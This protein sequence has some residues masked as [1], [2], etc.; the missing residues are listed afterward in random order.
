MLSDFYKYLIEKNIISKKKL[1]EAQ[2]K[3]KET[4]ISLQEILVRDYIKE[5]DFFKA[6]SEFFHIPLRHIAK[7][8]IPPSVIEEVPEE[9][10]KSYYMVPIAR[11]EN[12][13]E[14]GIVNPEDFTVNSVLNFIA[15]Q[16]RI[17]VKTFLITLSD[18]NLIFQQYGEI[19]GE[20]EDVLSELE[21]ES[22]AIKERPEVIEEETIAEAPISKIVAVIIRHAVSGGAS[23]IHIEPFGDRLRVRFRLD[24]VLYSSL[25]LEKK[26]LAP[27][28]SRF[29]ILANLRIDETRIPQ[30]GRFFANI[31]GR[32]I[33]FRVGTFPTSLGE[34][35]A[36]RILDPEKAIVNLEELGL[37]ER[38]RKLIEQTTKLPFGLLIFSGPT[39]S[40][41]TTS[42]YVILREL[43]KDDVNIVSLEDPV[44]YLIDGV[45]QSQVK[46]GIGYDFSSG[47]REMV[48]QDPDIIMV[49]EIRDKETASLV[50]HAALTGHL[51]LSTLHTNNAIGTLVRLR[52]LGIERYLIPSTLRLSVAQRL[53]RRLCPHCKEK[54]KANPL[55]EK[56]IRE[57]IE[58]LPPS[59]KKKINIPKE[60]FIYKP[61]GCSR[62]AGRGTRGRV[63]LFEILKMTSQ[64]EEIILTNFSPN[65]FSKEAKRQGM[66]TL[67]QDAVFKILDGIVSFEEA[68]KEVGVSF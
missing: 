33:D 48:R 62:C 53:V 50:T 35:I 16:H 29:K 58:S 32:R 59:E 25:F 46:P 10:A 65:E 45:N 19:K 12:K 9:I 27:I 64:L 17:K 49:G 4:L 60:I 18:F 14:V 37:N 2:D 31:L 39:G 41:K 43:N 67:K 56:I 38:N 57:E 36:V 44:E 54:V 63:G 61:Q 7:E 21:K 6:K 26:I 3:S 15:R 24:G 68:I 51:V 40:G 28:V 55:Q 66:I 52:D 34:K 1:S 13:L 42:Q 11:T 23:D 47:L 5:E 8:E 22:E 30:D 20:V